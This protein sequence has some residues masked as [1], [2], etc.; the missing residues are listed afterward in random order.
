[1]LR[2]RQPHRDTDRCRSTAVQQEIGGYSPE[3]PHAGDMEMWM[4]FGGRSPVA[5]LQAVQ[6]FYRW[7]SGNMSYAYRANQLRD[8]GEVA[9]VCDRMAARY[10]STFPDCRSWLQATYRRLGEDAFWTAS[11]AFDLGD[12]AAHRQYLDYA[13][14]VYPDIRRR[15]IWR[16]HRIKTLL[17]SGLWAKAR[18]SVDRIF[19]IRRGRPRYGRRQSAIR[20][21]AG[22]PT[23]P[24]PVA[25]L[26]ARG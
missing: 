5:V 1:M 3:F 16:K 23:R 7:H 25:E 9:Q 6:A 4:R 2:A 12:D 8:K 22:G 17:G 19:A 10:A 15:G 20:P 26:G 21:L 13:V 14:S 24:R 18:P 11:T